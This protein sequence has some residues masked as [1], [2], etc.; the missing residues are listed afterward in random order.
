[1]LNAAGDCSELG[2]IF[3]SAIEHIVAIKMV[4]TSF[5]QLCGIYIN[6]YRV[7]DIVKQVKRGKRRLENVYFFLKKKVV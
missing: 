3:C 4:R 6:I 2:Y 7:F 1:M 5:P